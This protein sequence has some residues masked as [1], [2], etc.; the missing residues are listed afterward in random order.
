MHIYKDVANIKG[1]G[2]T[3]HGNIF[4]L[5]FEIYDQDEKVIAVIGQIRGSTCWVLLVRHLRR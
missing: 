2:W 5:N 3:M 1:L 4:Q